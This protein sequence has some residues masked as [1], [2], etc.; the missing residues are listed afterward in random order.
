MPFLGA[1]VCFLFV[2]NGISEIKIAQWVFLSVLL[3]F[4][5]LSFKFQFSLIPLLGLLS[6]FY[7]MTELELSN[8]IGFGVW[9]LI[10]LIVYFTYS[11]KRSLL[12]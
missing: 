6:C 7:M 1:G 11:R 5:I 8:W 9:L 10:G 12:S 4:S 2:N 3:L